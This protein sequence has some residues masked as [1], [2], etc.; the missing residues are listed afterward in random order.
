MFLSANRPSRELSFTKLSLAVTGT[1]AALLLGSTGTI[2]WSALQHHDMFRLMEASLFGALAGF[3]VYGNLCYQIARLGRLLRVEAHGA[4]CSGNIPSCIG[5]DAPGLTVLVPSY[6]EE[7]SIIR[8]TLL[9]AA[10]Q[11]YPNKR[12]VL[13][14]D[15]PPAPK[16]RQDQTA[17]W[18]ARSLPFDLH[19]LL[20]DP[21]RH[22]KEAQSAFHSRRA[23]D[24]AALQMECV[25]LADCFNWT[26]E[27]FETQAKLTPIDS[28]TDAWFVEHILAQP[29][30][31]CREQASEWF[32]NS[33]RVSGRQ[34]ERL[35]QDMEAAY[36]ELCARFHVEF[37]VFERKQ[38]CNLSHEPN[39][40]MNLN[41]FLGLMGKRVKPVLRRDGL[42]LEETCSPTGGR[43]I[44]D[45]L[46]GFRYPLAAAMSTVLILLSLGAVLLINRVLRGGRLLAMLSHE[47]GEV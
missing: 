27:W 31:M 44:P 19:T 46:F 20:A 3:L 16:T 12:V 37:D 9:S 4:S 35:R 39:K 45:T 17:L 23:Q 43:V 33:A 5:A 6:R 7:I 1:A 30:N 38:Y 13:L 41:S 32:T 14:L 21:Y 18:A 10:L 29:A 34:S 25:W 15:D 28:H 42:Y 36:A 26:A 40:A 11:A 22:M 47:R 8:Q 2:A 24:A